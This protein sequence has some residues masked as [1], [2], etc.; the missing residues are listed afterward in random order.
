MN[1]LFLLISLLFLSCSQND[2]NSNDVINKWAENSKLIVRVEYN[3]ERID[4]FASGEEFHSKGYALIERKTEDKLFGFY[5]FGE[6]FDLNKQFIYDGK[7]EFRINKEKKNYTISNPGKGFLGSPGGQMVA[8]E[9]LFPETSY[10]NVNLIANTKNY[11]LIEYMYDDDTVSDVTNRIKA[12]EINKSTFL[13][14]QI[15]SSYKARGNSAVHKAIITNLKINA[16]VEK[17]LNEFKRK[18]LEYKRVEN[19]KTKPSVNLINSVAPEFQ[20]PILFDTSNHKAISREKLTLLDFWE[21]WCGPCVKSLP[22]VEKIHKKYYNRVEVIGIISDD[23]IKAKEFI[24]KRKLTFTNLVGNENIIK[25][26][27]VTGYPRYFLIDKNGIVKKGYYGFS[28]QI[29]IDIIQLLKE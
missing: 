7:K 12:I 15:T 23:L 1:N 20:L 18:L 26:F 16:D 21:V 14:Q 27:G 11:Y 24:N 17:S 10:K 5:F 25:K 4:K 28:S 29:E 22:E 3:V 13:P 9:I 19:E 6:R 8:K 2:L